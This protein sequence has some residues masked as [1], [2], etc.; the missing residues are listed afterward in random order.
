AEYGSKVTWSDPGMG[1]A[2]TPLSLK[3][4]NL[5]NAVELPFIDAT[6]PLGIGSFSDFLEKCR[7][8]FPKNV[9]VQIVNDDPINPLNKKDVFELVNYVIELYGGWKF[10]AQN[11]RKFLEQIE[12]ESRAQKELMSMLS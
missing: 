5:Y 2:F 3:I 4:E 7:D 6:N 8:Q 11:A 9:K 12:N 10:N 1:E